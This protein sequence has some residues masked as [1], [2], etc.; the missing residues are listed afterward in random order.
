MQLG[1]FV[2]FSVFAAGG[3]LIVSKHFIFWGWVISCWQWRRGDFTNRPPSNPHFA[4]LWGPHPAESR[5]G[6]RN[7]VGR[8]WQSSKGIA[9]SPV[10]IPPPSQKRFS[11]TQGRLRWLATAPHRWRGAGGASSTTVGRGLLT[12]AWG[13]GEKKIF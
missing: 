11:P 7:G 5:V 1:L 13:L 3:V 2:L 8:G 4:F 10:A 9:S 6:R 12:N